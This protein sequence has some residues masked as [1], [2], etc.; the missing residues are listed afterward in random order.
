MI[1]AQCRVMAVTHRILWHKT[2]CLFGPRNRMWV[3]R[4]SFFRVSRQPGVEESR[5]EGNRLRAF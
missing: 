3:T 2:F 5:E 4:G 1:L